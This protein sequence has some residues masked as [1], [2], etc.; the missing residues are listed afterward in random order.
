MPRAS[1]ELLRGRLL[2]WRG[3][4]PLLDAMAQLKDELDVHGFLG[5]E[6]R[7]GPHEVARL[8]AEARNLGWTAAVG[9]A[10]LTESSTSSGTLVAVRPY[11]GSSYLCGAECVDIMLGRAAGAHA[12]CW[13]RGGIALVSVYLITGIGAHEDNMDILYLLAAFKRTLACAVIFGGDWNMD[14]WML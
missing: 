6:H 5:Q 1:L 10:T 8:Q 9:E 7:Q 11:V 2:Q 4:G 14:P 13:L 3:K 12:R